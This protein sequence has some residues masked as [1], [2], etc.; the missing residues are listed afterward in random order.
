MKKTIVILFAILV[1]VAVGQ[2]YR[3]PVPR[4]K[5][6]LAQSAGAQSLY[7]TIVPGGDSVVVAGFEKP[8]RA[9]RES[10]FITNHLSHPVEGAVLEV[11][12][13]DTHGRMLHKATHQ[14]NVRIPTGETR[15]VEI[16]SFD[17]QGLFYYKLST[18]PPRA[19]QATPFDVKVQTTQVFILK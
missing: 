2:D 12:Y 19:K 9:V 7:D 10:M 16:P 14:I 8:L 13:L 6:R 4:I 18:L 1:I 11:T 3:R 15:R 17:R 5:Q